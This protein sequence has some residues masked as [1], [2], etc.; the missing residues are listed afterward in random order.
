MP[1]ILYKGKSVIS[2]G[3]GGGGSLPISS[4]PSPFSNADCDFWF[5]RGIKNLA[6]TS[7]G[8]S[9]GIPLQSY[10]ANKQETFLNFP[11]SS[12]LAVDSSAG[13]L[14]F[15][16]DRA[17]SIWWLQR[18][19]SNSYHAICAKDL[20]STPNRE[21]NLTYIKDGS[22]LDGR[23]VFTV[24]DSNSAGILS[25]ADTSVSAL[26]VFT[27]WVVNRSGSTFTLYKNG[28]AIASNSLSGTYNS[29]SQLIYL[30]DFATRTIVG[31]GCCSQFIGFNRALSGSEISA[32]YNG[33]NG[34][35]SL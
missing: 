4:V 9:G 10:F 13:F 11:Y 21:W 14:N 31:N 23:I 1:N 25:L 30:A 16:A 19:S 5:E 2:G 20:I 32:L 33:G 26:S 24:W 17:F 27:H 8:L 3:G 28:S 7:I 29:T 12:S 22:A 18:S 6:S 15:S 35:F 34:L